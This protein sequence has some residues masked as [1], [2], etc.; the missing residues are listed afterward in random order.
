MILM[1]K[2]VLKILVIYRSGPVRDHP[3]RFDCA[4]DLFKIS[5]LHQELFLL[6]AV[7]LT[8]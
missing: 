7:G 4:E 2:A 5:S 6:K 3:D 8:A 1:L